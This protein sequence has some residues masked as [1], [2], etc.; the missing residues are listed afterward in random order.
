M[1]WG[2]SIAG[3]YFNT[4]SSHALLRLAHFSWRKVSVTDA[5][6]IGF[7]S[8]FLWLL[9]REPKQN[10]PATRRRLPLKGGLNMNTDHQTWTERAIW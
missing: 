6:H 5:N 3:G 4:L 9:V 10:R 2:W 7:A 1:F 8:E